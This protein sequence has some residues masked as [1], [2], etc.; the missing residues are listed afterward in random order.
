MDMK[1]VISDVILD[2]RPGGI[3]LYT[4]ALKVKKSEQSQGCRS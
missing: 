2:L 3:V 1:T 4:S